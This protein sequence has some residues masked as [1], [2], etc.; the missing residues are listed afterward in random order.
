MTKDSVILLINSRI[1]HYLEEQEVAKNNQ[2][3]LRMLIIKEVIVNF[4]NLIKAI[5]DTL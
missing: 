3:L 1:N 4:R 5:Q 2:N